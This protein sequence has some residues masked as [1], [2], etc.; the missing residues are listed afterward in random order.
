[1][2]AGPGGMPAVSVVGGSYPADTEITVTVYSK[3]GSVLAQASILVQKDPEIPPPAAYA[4]LNP[5]VSS[6]S[7]DPNSIV[8]V[9]D[10]VYSTYVTVTT[11]SQ[12]TDLYYALVDKGDPNVPTA[13]A[14]IRQDPGG[15]PSM[16]VSF[17][18]ATV[19]GGKTT[20]QIN[21]FGADRHYWLYVV[22]T[23]P[24]GQTAT[25]V[26]KAEIDTLQQNVFQLLEVIDMS[27]GTGRWKFGLSH[28]PTN[29]QGTVYYLITDN[30]FA[31]M[32]ADPVNDL[33]DFATGQRDASTAPVTILAKGYGPWNGTHDSVDA[34]QGVPGDNVSVVLEYRGVRLLVEG[35]F[36]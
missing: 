31:S 17:G 5:T 13:Q 2:A 14:L 4:R 16:T 34:G 1:M 21:S 9:F 10:A 36:K 7:I 35:M 8:T 25:G 30:P 24:G 19:T 32:V 11:T 3:R 23:L 26:A 27:G 6:V 20:L 29:A 22:G 33:V 28:A 12:V 15:L 18:H